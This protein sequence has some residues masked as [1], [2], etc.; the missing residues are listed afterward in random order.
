MSS[1]SA[2]DVWGWLSDLQLSS[3]T[4]F[5]DRGIDGDMLLNMTDDDLKDELLVL[6]KFH[7]SKIIRKIKAHEER[8]EQ[9]QKH[10]EVS[11]FR[12]EARKAERRQERD[13]NG[14]D[15]RSQRED[16]RVCD[17]PP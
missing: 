17:L 12:L 14:D 6:D 3:Y 9:Q 16:D 10:Q 8:I 5:R 7:R 2:D 1:W 13:H 4:Q 11:A 15:H